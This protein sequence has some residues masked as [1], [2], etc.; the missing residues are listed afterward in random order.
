MLNIKNIW[1][2]SS[3]YLEGRDLEAVNWNRFPKVLPRK[4]GKL[5]VQFHLRN[6]LLEPLNGLNSHCSFVIDSV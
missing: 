4:H 6:E 2:K 3:A 5:L 1:L